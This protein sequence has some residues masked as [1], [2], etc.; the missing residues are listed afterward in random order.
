MHGVI[1]VD[2][3]EIMLKGISVNIPWKENGFYVLGTANNGAD[4]LALARR[5]SPEIILTDIRMPMID[6]ISMAEKIKAEQPDV[7][8]IF[9]TGYD[10]F[11]YAKLAISLGADG[12][13]LKYESDEA[14]IREI[15]SIRDK[16]VKQRAASREYEMDRFNPM[17]SD[18]RQNVAETFSEDGE[19]K[20]HLWHEGTS[21]MK[22]SHKQLVY[23][24][25]K[26]VRA[27]YSEDSLSVAQIA[28]AVHICAA[29]TSTLFKKYTKMNLSDYIVSVRMKEAQRLLQETSLSIEKISWQIG[30]SNSHYFST[31]F[32]RYSGCTP[33]AFR[34]RRNT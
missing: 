28:G 22:V 5:V 6:G 11:Q 2:D 23:K 9:L 21:W 19:F 15:I 13:I 26:Y 8:I 24:I 10:N 32:K 31:A 30:Y 25:I 27:N 20:D 4:G 3:D 33:S 17:R 7:K 16:A 29:Y 14:I 18:S 12:Y 34:R 1:I